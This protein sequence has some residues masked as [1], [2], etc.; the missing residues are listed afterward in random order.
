M[1]F[2]TRRAILFLKILSSAVN[3]SGGA[4]KE[5][6]TERKYNFHEKISIGF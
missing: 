3:N 2:A 1:V 5:I 6:P 4:K